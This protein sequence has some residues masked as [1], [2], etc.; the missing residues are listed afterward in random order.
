VFDRGSESLYLFQRIRDEAHRF[1][2]TYHRQKRGAAMVGTVL[3]QV[4]GLGRVRQRKLLE[5]F[6]SIDELRKA[7]L[8]DLQ[9]FSWLPESVAESIYDRLHGEFKPNVFKENV[10]L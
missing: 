3:D 7:S 9:Q 10:E 6:G 5:A 4:S 2:I 1:A 8:D